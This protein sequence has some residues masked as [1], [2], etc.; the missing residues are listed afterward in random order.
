MLG[1][2]RN[3]QGLEARSLLGIVVRVKRSSEDS[4]TE[5]LVTADEHLGHDNG[6]GGIIKMC[7][8]PFADVEEMK[9]ALIERHNKKVPN[10]QN[11]TTIHC[12][13][14]FWKTMTLPECAEYISRL[15][16]RH[17]YVWGNHEEVFDRDGSQFL[18]M[19]F[20][21]METR[22]SIKYNKK[23]IIL[24]H[25]AM[26]VWPQSHR[27]SWMLYGHSHNELPPQGLSFDIGVD[28]HNYEP[29]SLA[30]IAEKMSGLVQHHHVPLDKPCSICGRLATVG[31]ARCQ[32]RGAV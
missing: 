6:I 29:W 8:R 5:Y 23:T 18:K 27:G 30:E 14:M 11:Y 20:T 24:D 26:R 2:L 1:S 32:E 10:N 25:F 19:M 16:G 9:E 21:W 12:G 28:G 22:T 7:N 3:Q 4:M 15:N 17:A 13:D 31:C